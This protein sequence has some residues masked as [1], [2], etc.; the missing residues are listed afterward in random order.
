MDIYDSRN[1]E[2][3]IVAFAQ[4]YMA[5]TLSIKRTTILEGCKQ[6]VSFMDSIIDFKSVFDLIPSR[7]LKTYT[8]TNKKKADEEKYAL[9]HACYSAGIDALEPELKAQMLQIVNARRSGLTRAQKQIDDQLEINLMNNMAMTLALAYLGTR[10]ALSKLG[11][12]RETNRAMVAS[13]M[14]NNYLMLTQGNDGIEDISPDERPM[15]I[16]GPMPVPVPV[17]N[18][19]GIED[20]SPEPV[21]PPRRLQ[22]TIRANALTG[23]PPSPTYPRQTSRS[24]RPALLSQEELYRRSL[25]TRGG[26]TR[27]THG[28]RNKRT[29][30]KTHKKLGKR[31]THS[32]RK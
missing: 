3:V 25:T 18:R 15:Q 17:Q 16:L 2:P 1:H 22:L 8:A 7:T 4:K 28:K 11:R 26:K 20:I 29:K 12:G 31:K 19:A 9:E 14:R 24:V 10:F 21:G 30:H 23:S 32:K 6:P 27:K 5:E 13:T